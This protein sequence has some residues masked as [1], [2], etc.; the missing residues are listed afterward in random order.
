[1]H[2][3]V[4]AVLEPHAQQVECFPFQLINHRGRLHSEAYWIINPL[5][6]VSC[7]N[8]GLSRITYSAKDPGMVVTLDEAVFDAQETANCPDLF[9]LKED[10][11]TYVISDAIAAEMQR[12]Q[13]TN[14]F[15]ED[16]KVV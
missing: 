15:L 1:M 8:P 9:R 12:Q 7:L 3:A 16:I 11:R 13:F 14:I 5:D 6:F 10:P 4:K 2:A